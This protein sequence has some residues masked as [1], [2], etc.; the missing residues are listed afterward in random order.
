[1]KNSFHKGSFFVPFFQQP[2][3]FSCPRKVPTPPLLFSNL[4]RGRQRFNLQLLGYTL[5][6]FVFFPEFIVKNE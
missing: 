6:K 5:I 3:F 4:L 1:M 2:E